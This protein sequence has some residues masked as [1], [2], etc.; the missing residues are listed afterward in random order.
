VGDKP[1]Y[2]KEPYHVK[3][4]GGSVEVDIPDNSITTEKLV[5]GSVTEG[6]LSQEVITRIDKNKFTPLSGSSNDAN[7]LTSQ[8]IYFNSGGYGLRNAPRDNYGWI[9]IVS[10]GHSNNHLRGGQLYIDYEGFNFRG[11]DGDTFTEWNSFVNKN[12]VEQL[13]LISDP[14]TA[15]NEDIANKL[16]E[17]LTALKS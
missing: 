10:H 1:C 3:L 2:S 17:V 16:N 6:K 7:E 14:T 8:G 13:E 11:Y 5:D 4:D 12:N 15:T 9:L